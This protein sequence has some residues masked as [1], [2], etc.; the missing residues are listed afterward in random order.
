[1]PST[2]TP[3]SRRSRIASSRRSS[4]MRS[5]ALG[6]APT[7]GSTTPSAARIRSWSLVT[8]AD[9]PTCSNAFSTERRLPM[10]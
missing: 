3:S 4:R 9:T 10:P 2:G 7:P 5:I 1:M 8:S 6:N